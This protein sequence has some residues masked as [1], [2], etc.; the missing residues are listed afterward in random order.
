MVSQDLTVADGVDAFI[1]LRRS[2]SEAGLRSN[3]A[4]LLPDELPGT[5]ECG[6]LLNGDEQQPRRHRPGSLD[7]EHG[8]ERSIP[9]ELDSDAGD[10]NMPNEL[11]SEPG[12]NCCRLV[13][14]NTSL[15]IG[16]SSLDAEHGSERSI[17]GELDSDAGDFNMPNEL[18][19]EPGE[20]RCRLVC[21]NTT[22]PIGGSSLDAE[23]GSE[24]SIRGELDSDAGDFNMPNE[25]DSEAGENC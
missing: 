15:P 24:R 17:R 2:S 10:F 12:E 4:K 25:L 19:S 3:S 18:D 9:S 13:C 20:N 5:I 7:A 8:S 22:L 16:G 14:C 1:T 23:H 21:C 11:D 6:T